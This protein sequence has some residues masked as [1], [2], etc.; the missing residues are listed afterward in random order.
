M[1]HT[2]LNG[3]GVG[4]CVPCAQVALRDAEELGVALIA[5]QSVQLSHGE[6]EGEPA[7]Q[8]IAGPHRDEPRLTNGVEREQVLHLLRATAHRQ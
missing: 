8:D 4:E 1:A 7:R 2:G 6:A 3:T 5:R